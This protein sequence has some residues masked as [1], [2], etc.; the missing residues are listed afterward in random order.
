MAS[1]RIEIVSAKGNTVWPGTTSPD[2]PGYRTLKSARMKAIEQIKRRGKESTY[3]YIQKDLGYGRWSIVER[4]DY[5]EYI[6][7]WVCRQYRKQG[8][9]PDSSTRTYRVSPNTGG[10]LDYDKNWR[11]L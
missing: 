11:Y 5:S 9:S 8:I 7:D 6:S 10:L 2:W 3:V 4:I 1:Y